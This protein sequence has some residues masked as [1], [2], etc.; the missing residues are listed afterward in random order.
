MDL[1]ATQR[2]SGFTTFLL[3][4][5]FTM[6]HL[7]EL[8]TAFRK[9]IE[10][11]PRSRLPITFSNFPRG[12]CGDVTLLLGAFLIEQGYEPFHYLLG[13]HGTSSH[14]WLQRGKLVIDI[15]ADQ[16]SDCD[17]SVIVSDSSEWHL[18][19]NGKQQHIADYHVFGDP[20][21]TILGGAYS[22]IISNLATK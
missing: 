16:F 19:L 4:D 7:I 12:S 9:A 22:L 21:K 15:T 6:K 8:A 10:A 11:C 20:T 14:A 13:E 2:V 5:I 3:T 1:S 18:Q 17:C